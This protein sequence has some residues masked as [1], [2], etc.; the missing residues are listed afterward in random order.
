[1]INTD[2]QSYEFL[3]RKANSDRLWLTNI[4]AL[5]VGKSWKIPIIPE[6][7]PH[8]GMSIYTSFPKNR[9]IADDFKKH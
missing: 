4:L 7:A 9:M 1:M 3:I 2:G 8:I 5:I 6:I